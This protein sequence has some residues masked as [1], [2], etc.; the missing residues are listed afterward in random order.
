MNTID[1]E[2]IRIK[3]AAAVAAKLRYWDAMRE[4]E[5]LL[6]PNGDASYCDEHAIVNQ[7]DM[8]A[9]S[10]DDPD[11]AERCITLAEVADTLKFIKER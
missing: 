8:L 10:I 4:L 3:L 9:A 5:E 7:I 1:P 2:E 6:L 11:A